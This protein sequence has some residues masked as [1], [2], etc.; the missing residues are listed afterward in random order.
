MQ[1][2]FCVSAPSHEACF[3]SGTGRDASHGP[4]SASSSSCHQVKAK[5]ICKVVTPS[6]SQLA[7]A[8]LCSAKCQV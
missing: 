5:S 1:A 3:F 2:Y 7:D 6:A 4:D 8:G